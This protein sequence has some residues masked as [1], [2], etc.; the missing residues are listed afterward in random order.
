M[1]T[2]PGEPTIPSCDSLACMLCVLRVFGVVL[3]G[4][5]VSLLTLC[6][7]ATE[8]I[9]LGTQKLERVKNTQ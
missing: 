6:K 7:E 8:D 4:D 3:F 9:A 1:I 2:L 5:I